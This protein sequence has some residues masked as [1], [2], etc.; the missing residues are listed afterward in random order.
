LAPLEVRLVET[1]RREDS[2]HVEETRVYEA[3]A[4][5]LGE[6]T[7]PAPVFRARPRDGGR[8]RATIGEDVT[9]RVRTALDPASPGP[10][11]FPGDPLPR[12]E[13]E[14]SPWWVPWSIGGAVAV[15]ALGLGAWAL[16]R[17]AAR[18]RMPAV[19]EE[20]VPPPPPAHARALARLRRLRE[21][22]VQSRDEI[23]SCYLEASAVL[24][25][26]LGERF[27]LR[28]RERT[29]EEVLAAPQTARVLAPPHR[30]LVGEVL[31]ECDLVKFA[32]HLPPPSERDRVLDSAEEFLLQ[33]GNG[34][35]SEPAADTPAAGSA[36]S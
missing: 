33:T 32:R 12:P 13:P 22:R 17:R 29:T 36:G 18:R 4:F 26:Y 5:A 23:E 24:R 6:V 27:S 28:T 19:V 11:E 34:K 16:H 21:R 35:A 10:P 15:L 31:A 30:A 25:E 3:Y 8:E 14:P 20:A 1:R 2:R 7:I 9:L